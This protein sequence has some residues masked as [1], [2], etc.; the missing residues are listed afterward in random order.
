MPLKHLYDPQVW[1]RLPG[2][3]SCTD[4]G[5][6][7]YCWH[8]HC[9]T[10]CSASPQRS[11]DGNVCHHPDVQ[12]APIIHG[13]PSTLVSLSTSKPPS[14]TPSQVILMR[15]HDTLRPISACNAHKRKFPLHEQLQL[16]RKRLC[17]LGGLRQHFPAALQQLHIITVLL[18]SCVVDTYTRE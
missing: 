12:Y 11:T 13:E 3:S 7:G 4:Q 16:R 5:G 17:C 8:W 10:C 18:V 15:W 1:A 9:D 14:S 2:R 6:A